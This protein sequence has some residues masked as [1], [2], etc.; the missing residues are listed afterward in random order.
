MSLR[1]AHASLYLTGNSWR[2]VV[3]PRLH[4]CASSRCGICDVSRAPSCRA[5]KAAIAKTLGPKGLRHKWLRLDAEGDTLVL[6]TNKSSLTARLGVQ[7]LL[8]TGST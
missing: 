8:H 7:V 5:R 4:T 1:L 2:V 6:T 3:L